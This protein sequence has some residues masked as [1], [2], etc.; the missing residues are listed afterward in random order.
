[1]PRVEELEEA[2]Q[3]RV[4]TGL[5]RLLGMLPRWA[6]L[7]VL[8]TSAQSYPSLAESQRT[9]LASAHLHRVVR[10]GQPQRQAFFVS[11]LGHSR[12]V[13]ERSMEQ[14]AEL[15]RGWSVQELGQLSVRVSQIRADNNHV[16]SVASLIK[17][18]CRRH[19]TMF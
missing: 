18:S 8:L 12:S 2:L 17:V 15:T 11:L 4:G 5:D 13:S 14:L 7:L 6:P 3:V 1:M 10:P 16:P 19:V 9:A